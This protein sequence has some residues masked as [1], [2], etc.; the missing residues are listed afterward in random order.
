MQLKTL[1]VDDDPVSIK[2]IQKFVETTDSLEL[3]G[4][5]QNAIEAANMLQSSEVDLVLLDIEMPEMSGLDLI[6]TLNQRPQFILVTSQKEYAI[7]AFDYEVT[8]YLLK[9]VQYKRFLKAVNRA[10]N[11]AQKTSNNG[12]QAPEPTSK[13]IFIKEKNQF[14]RIDK[15]TIH[16]IEAFGDYVN[17]YTNEKRYT[18]HSTMKK[19]EAKFTED[20]QFLR[21]HR[22]Y[23]VN[24]DLIQSIDDNMVFIKNKMLPIGGSY[25]QKLLK[26]LNLI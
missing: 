12:Q 23:I 7:E 6:N 13:T 11:N 5:A 9:P 10:L 3:A 21:I 20:D 22:S 24:L 17:I 16:Y 26:R 14:S 2:V 19:M 15:S 1:I 8:D 4:S 25:K 18:I